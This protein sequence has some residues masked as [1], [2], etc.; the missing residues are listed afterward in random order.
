MIHQIKCGRQ[1][2]ERVP[3]RNALLA[4]QGSDEQK[5]NGHGEKAAGYISMV[6]PWKIGKEPAVKKSGIDGS[7]KE[8][9]VVQAEALSRRAPGIM[10]R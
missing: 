3:S 7:I 5:R 2:V 1:K 10:Q 8:G 4:A 6:D 9:E